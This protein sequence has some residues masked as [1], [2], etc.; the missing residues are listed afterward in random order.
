MLHSHWITWE[1][2][3]AELLSLHVR[4]PADRSCFTWSANRYLEERGHTLGH[5]ES[6]G[7]DRKHMLKTQ[8]IN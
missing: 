2:M 8:G 6:I 7:G 5:K 4:R 3:R 1:T